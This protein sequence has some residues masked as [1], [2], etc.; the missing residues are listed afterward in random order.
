M[1]YLAV[2]IG[3]SSGRLILGRHE[4]GVIE[5]K[6][7]HRFENKME[8]KNGH[9][10]WDVDKLFKEILAGLR[11]CH[12]ADEAPMSM[13]I[14]CFGVDFVL[15]DE[16]NR[17]LGDFVAYR[18]HRTNGMIEKLEK[19]ISPKLMYEK[20]GIQSQI[21]NTIYQLMAIKETQP[22]LLNKAKRFLTLPDYFN[23]LLTGKFSNEYTEASTTQLLNAHTRKFDKEILEVLGLP[24][25]IFGEVSMPGTVIGDFTDEVKAQVGFS[26]KVVLPATHD[27]G[28]AVIAVP[29]ETDSVYL[30]SGTWSLMGVLL[31]EPLCNEKS[32]QYGF[33]NEGGYQG[34]IRFLKNIMGLWILQSVKRELSQDVS[35]DELERL[36]EQSKFSHAIDVSNQIFFS[37][38]SMTQAVYDNLAQIGAPKPNNIG[39]LVRSIFLGLA[40]IYDSTVKELEELTGKT[41]SDIHIIGGGSQNK[42][43]NEM[44]ANKTKKTVYAGP[45]EATAIGNIIVQMLKSGEFSSL[46]EAKRCIAKSFEIQKY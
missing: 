43:L 32:R 22:E 25:D 3:A 11:K 30:S 5:L 1:N 46:A 9:L 34:Q 27:T 28:S 37:P 40:E 21:F 42:L 10:C 4:N 2:D 15:L 12:E 16:N 44:T 19:L 24:H 14:D 7:M 23:F 41:Y 45:I 31:N 6:E 18:D 20:T 39:E 8:E 33:T 13:G 38:K 36:A 29:N 35:F 17:P 26:A